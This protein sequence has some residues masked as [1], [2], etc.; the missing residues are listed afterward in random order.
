MILAVRKFCKETGKPGPCKGQKRGTKQAKE[1]AKG[2][3]SKAKTTEPA[4]GPPKPKAKPQQ[5]PAAASEALAAK[6]KA[7][8]AARRGELIAHV[9][10]LDRQHKKPTLTQ[11]AK[12]LGHTG[13]IKTK[14]DALYAI[15]E[16]LAKR[17]GRKEFFR[18]RVSPMYAS[19]KTINKFR[20][21]RAKKFGGKC[22][23]D[24][25]Q[26][27]ESCPCDTRHFQDGGGGDVS[28]NGLTPWV[29]IFASGTHQGQEY[30]PGQIDQAIR[31]FWRIS[32]GPKKLFSPTAVTGHEEDEDQEIL[33]NTGIPAAGVVAD[34]ARKIDTDQ[35]GNP[36]VKLLARFRDVPPEMVDAINQ[37][38]YRTVSAEFYENFDDQ[39][40][41]YGFALRRVAFLGGE[42]PEVKSLKG[43]P[44][45]AD[46]RKIC[47][48]ACVA[49][50]CK[51]VK[52]K[53]FVDWDA[54]VHKC[55]KCGGPAITGDPETKSTYRGSAKCQD[56]GHSQ[57]A[58]NRQPT[59]K[60]WVEFAERHGYG[61][62]A[63]DG[64]WEKGP[65]GGMRK[66]AASG[67]WIYKKGGGGSNSGGS[68]AKASK[69]AG[70]KSG[71]SKLPG[72]PTSAQKASAIKGVKSASAAVKKA[73]A[74]ERKSQG[75]VQALYEAKKRLGKNLEQNKQTL[76]YQKKAVGVEIRKGNMSVDEASQMIHSL[77][78]RIKDGEAKLAKAETAHKKKLAAHKNKQAAT[79]RARARMDKA[80][81]K[82]KELQGKKRAEYKAKPG[83]REAEIGA[84]KASA[85]YK[86]NQ[87]ARF[88]TGTQ[89]N[90]L[91]AQLQPLK[92]QL[93]NV[94]ENARQSKQLVE[95]LSSKKP[96][97]AAE[98]KTN[99]KLIAKANNTIRYAAQLQDR[100]DLKEKQLGQ[101]Q[102]ELKT[103]QR[104][105][106]HLANK[107]ESAYK[108]L[109]KT[110][111]KYD[112]KRKKLS[113][114][115]SRMRDT[116]QIRTFAERRS[117]WL[118][119]SEALRKFEDTGG[120]EKGPK[121]GMRKKS[122]G[123]N[124]IYKKKG[125]GGSSASPA[126]VPEKKKGTR[127]PA[128]QKRRNKRYREFLVKK[129][130]QMTNA[131]A[132]KVRSVAKTS[133]KALFTVNGTAR[134]AAKADAAAGWQQFRDKAKSK[135][136]LIDKALGAAEAVVQNAVVASV[137]GYMKLGKTAAKAASKANRQ[138]GGGVAGAVAA[139]GKI[140]EIGQKKFRQQYTKNFARDQK[141]YGTAAAA[142]LGA[143]QGTAAM[144]SYTAMI[145]PGM[146]TVNSLAG[147]VGNLVGVASAGNVPGLASLARLPFEGAFMAI[148]GISSFVKGRLNKVKREIDSGQFAERATL[149]VD[150][151]A[152]IVKRRL[153]E[154]FQEVTGKPTQVPLALVYKSL[155]SVTQG[156]PVLPI[157]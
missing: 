1:P 8:P 76:E 131:G 122:K 100:H 43:L 25:C 95:R 91:S 35:H 68:A 89:V 52:P 108:H 60:S 132:A 127:T 93:P 21:M 26:N 28:Q 19:A 75:E 153:E 22:G 11:I 73:V 118:E 64:G 96:K 111:D 38:R 51:R 107:H 85:D 109:S 33:R 59:H 62:F 17:I 78:G 124:W 29:E 143:V 110:R 119:F 128:Q 83:L 117:L 103:L 141:K 9:L 56:C 102:N 57:V 115:I 135:S 3:Q 130:R 70:N 69:P 7:N 87:K 144:A 16:Q 24:S 45:F 82:V 32:A 20:D 2:R 104:E 50:F 112:P 142:V 80:K 5:A 31:N 147:A 98:R 150:K 136:A 41:D 58:V 154:H 138:A 27:G 114:V 72:G 149:T 14:D 88:K 157:A 146:P 134:R 145:V 123:G 120:W 66:K 30:T 54:Q 18:E 105:Q 129:I 37:K 6:L 47:R 65:R 63:E 125:G 39:G 79:D 77:R 148:K 74:A 133:G 42:I 53:K 156:Q 121:G 81:G 4:S 49:Q 116:Q 126:A 139:A 23:C 92:E 44:K 48:F 67:K 137:H 71:T 61:R 151:I 155:A 46:G 40:N 101:A 113:E 99:E 152:A 15:H 97:T 34:V 140:A 10:D 94:L 86:R 84:T 12:D 36:I 55:D 13:K 106:L 90:E